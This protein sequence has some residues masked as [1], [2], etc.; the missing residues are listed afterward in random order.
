MKNIL[1]FVQTFLLMNIITLQ[2]GL[3]REERELNISEIF[4]IEINQTINPASLSHLRHAIKKMNGRKDCALAIQINTPGG[5]VS[6]T[7]A[8]ITE[9]GKGN[10]PFI[11]IVGPEGG[12]ATSAG[13][14]LSAAS[15]LLLMNPGTNIGAATPIT[16]KLRCQRMREIKR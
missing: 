14:I 12:S 2:V 6:V 5:L 16:M 13:A 11:A 1:R 4:K 9:I 7:K 8:M 3:T 15:H 10:I